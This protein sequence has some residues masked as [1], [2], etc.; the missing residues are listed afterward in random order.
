MGESEAHEAALMRAAREL[1]G[2]PLHLADSLIAGT[3][4]VHN[5]AVVTRNVK[6]FV[7]LDI[8]LV[9]PFKG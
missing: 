2:H 9:N 7:D 8:E 3:A 6:D 4:K 1:E 5:L